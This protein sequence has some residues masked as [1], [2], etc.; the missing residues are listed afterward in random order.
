MNYKL[1]SLLVVVFVIQ[2]AYGSVLDITAPSVVVQG[3][4]ETANILVT[5]DTTF[6][7]LIALS[8]QNLASLIATASFSSVDFTG[9]GPYYY[10]YSWD[11]TGL[12]TGAYLIRA[13]LSYLNNTFIDA[14]QAAGIVNSSAPKIIEKAPTGIVTDI[15]TTLTL[16]TD[17][18]ATCRYDTI[19]STYSN[20]SNKFSITGSEH[21]SQ[22]ITG[23]TGSE[24][25]YYVA[26]MDT[27][28]YQMNQSEMINFKVDLP[29]TAEVSLSDESPLKAGI[30]EVSV[31]ASK[32]LP[33]APTLSYSFNDD[34]DSKKLI[35]LTGSDALWKGY[36]IV[37]EEDD[38]K[39]GTFYF[40]GTDYL[41]T[42]GDVITE[43]KIFIVDTSKPTAPLNM[44][45][46][47]TTD[48]NIRLR[49]YY[50][51]EPIDEFRIYRATSSSVSYIDY[52][53]STNNDTQFL[54]T[55]T[56]DKV[57]YYYRVNA[58]DE[59]GNIGLLS[60]E[61]YAT[62]L[63]GEQKVAVDNITTIAEPK[64]LPPNLVEKVDDMI[65][66]FNK[67]EIDVKDIGINLENSDAEKKALIES[68]GIIDEVNK[69]KEAISS[70]KNQLNALKLEFKTPSELDSELS[71]F[72]LEINKIQK[73]MPKDIELLE[74]T[75]F[76]Q[77]INEDETKLAVDML[78][79]DFTDKEKKEYIA[80]NK[81]MQETMK[82]EANIK[83]V[84]ITYLDE[85]IKK[86]IFVWKKISRQDP[87][88]IKDVML[89]EII[90]TD[91]VENIDEME[92]EPDDYE[93]IKEDPLIIKWGF[94]ELDYNGA[95]IRYIIEN[96]KSIDKIKEIKDTILVGPLQLEDNSAITGYSIF[97]VISE[98]LNLSR[99]NLIAI[100]AG[101]LVI[102]ALVGYYF[103]MPRINI[104]AVRNN[105]RSRLSQFR[106]P[107]EYRYLDT[108]N[109][110]DV[111]RL[112][113]INNLDTVYKSKNPKDEFSVINEL[114]EK[115][116]EYLITD[117]F[118]KAA[119]LYPKIELLY[120][121]LPKALKPE[122][123]KKCIEIKK[124]ISSKRKEFESAF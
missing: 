4:S 95:T 86:Q 38:N 58:V 40:S 61:V 113:R 14:G 82:I 63:N 114:I 17:E 91:S 118:D 60:E 3:N 85:T 11:I 45:P 57:T 9:S 76:I 49:W 67:L 2:L 31:L 117:D 89:V 110:P 22:L 21:H 106:A 101:I 55:S 68:L 103:F 28:G 123:Y 33:K 108:E 50:E 36:M 81:K 84:K 39:V 53:A 12:N 54:D 19:N 98:S 56:T 46:I 30:I 90:P 64:V 20:L 69:A 71:K 112:E 102:S 42:I 41:G 59:A 92:F 105:M 5:S 111:Q 104:S 15:S 43:G 93:K 77:S 100:I 7:G 94:T 115:S 10:H 35:S 99:G 75:D 74:Q 87:N 96:D 25:T 23:L 116:Q 119:S 73:T 78:F 97:S 62:S 37:K 70:S 44:E 122:A 51:G 27:K 72:D 29:A 16:T 109:Y 88:S 34:P 48:G 120:K 18:I 26:C 32:N 6:D 1:I 80:K 121:N 47:L 24:Y 52:Y 65:K 79:K 124:E 8:Y 66:K 13:N 83:S 107:G